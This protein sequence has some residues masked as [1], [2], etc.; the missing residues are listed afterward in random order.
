MFLKEKLYSKKFISF[1]VFFLALF[2]NQ[3]F[4]NKGVFPLDSFSHFDIGYRVL[5]G[6]LPFKD[7]WVVSGPLIDFLQAFLFF[8]FGVNWQSYLLNASILNG[9]FAVLTYKL[10]LEFE[11][12][13]KS[14]F[15][16]TICV[17]ILAYPSSGTPFVDHHSTFF[18]IISI[19]LLVF[20]I[21]KDELVYW[22]LVPFLL[23]FAFLSKQVPATYIFFSVIF[24]IIYN[25]T[26][27]DVRKIT[28]KN[29]FFTLLLSSV[30]IFVLLLLFFY[31]T[32]VSVHSFI[33]QYINYPRE[34][35]QNR[36]MK[37]NYDLKKTILDFKFIHLIFFTLILLNINNLI[38]E[39]NYFKKINFKLFLISFLLLV[40]LIQHQIV[41]KNQIFIFFLI[42]LFSAF[43]QIELNKYSD[44][45]K[46]YLILLLL[47]TC[48]LTTL[49][50]HKRFNLERKFH[51]LNNVNF[52]NSVEATILSNSFK[53]LKW[54]TPNKN[55]KK[56][57]IDEI[58]SIKKNINILKNDSSNKM[59]ITNYSFFSVLL[60]KTSNS[61]TRWF[62]GDDS[63]FPQKD[64][65]LF[66]VYKNFLLKKI[67]D[68]NI[69][70]IY[71]IND[72]SEENLLNYLLPDCINKTKVN[73][74]M[75]KYTINKNCFDL[76]GKQ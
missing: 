56:A 68:K 33:D 8:I 35:G 54:I 36:Y 30:T 47:T 4:G 60:K 52:S 9:V 42:P 44:K 15:F 38:K 24:L 18:S 13:K 75:Y 31:A 73:E 29:I 58:N 19:Y 69:S 26:F 51:E 32:G 2:F 6:E 46:K 65:K 61:P 48:L 28:N 63:A 40:S 70:N 67:Q 62:P 14:S 1:L 37:L 55:S 74:Y 50:Y 57:T 17:A 25:F 10:F 66:I 23:C 3:Y 71:I 12:D 45:Y 5:N 49:K 11:L 43:V 53:G 41:T 7:Y 20:A 16:Y 76:Y 59:L 27:R 39:K 64:S 34:I 22:F 21:K 72:V